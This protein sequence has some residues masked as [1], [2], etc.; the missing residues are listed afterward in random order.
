VLPLRDL[1]GDDPRA[2]KR[3]GEVDI[4]TKCGPRRDGV[5]SANARVGVDT[6]RRQKM[7]TSVARAGWTVSQED[8]RFDRRRRG[9]R[10]GNE[11]GRGAHRGCLIA[12]FAL[13][14]LMLSQ[15]RV[16]AH[17]HKWGCTPM[18]Q[19]AEQHGEVRLD[20][21]QVISRE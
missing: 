19:K 3:L 20:Q 21:Q 8:R 12:S 11:R 1:R 9:W 15:L 13:S 5:G 10:R 6:K 16:R 4:T 14:V 2:V 17:A 7:K 18:R